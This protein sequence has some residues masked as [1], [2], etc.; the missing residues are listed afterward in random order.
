MCAT[1]S[2]RGDEEQRDDESSEEMPDDQRRPLKVARKGGD[3]VLENEVARSLV[4]ANERRWSGNGPVEP[5]ERVA[6]ANN[7]LRP[8]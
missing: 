2:F 3:A 5:N 4:I 8:F 7:A 1:I 6:G